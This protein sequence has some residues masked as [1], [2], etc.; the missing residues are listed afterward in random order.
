[1]QT[2]AGREILKAL[3]QLQQT[4]A[5]VQAIREYQKRGG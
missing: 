1:M 5:D 3:W 2:K 4:E